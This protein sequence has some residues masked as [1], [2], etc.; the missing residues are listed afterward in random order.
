MNPAKLVTF[1]AKAKDANPARYTTRLMNI[2]AKFNDQHG[3][4]RLLIV[5]YAIDE[6]VLEPPK[7]IIV[8]PAATSFGEVEPVWRAE[9]PLINFTLRKNGEV[10]TVNTHA[11]PNPILSIQRYWRGGSKISF[12]YGSSLTVKENSSLIK[13]ILHNAINSKTI[14]F[15][16]REPK[17]LQP[18]G[19]SINGTDPSNPQIIFTGQ[20]DQDPFPTLVFK[21]H[22]KNILLF[23]QDPPGQ[24][25]LVSY[26][27][28][29]PINLP[30]PSLR[31]PEIILANPDVKSIHQIWT[32][33][34]PTIQLPLSQPKKMIEVNAASRILTR[35]TLGGLR[36]RIFL[37]N[38]NTYVVNQ[39]R[40]QIDKALQQARNHWENTNCL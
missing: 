19:F 17:L 31:A 26:Q 8:T 34:V 3:N 40:S 1:E 28:D 32:S 14:S 10:V 38:G 29:Y 20:L 23:T 7:A 27:Y 16:Q 6:I 13:T 4:A 39:R 24:F 33:V 36:T 22:A 11:V 12:F 18:I 9:Q 15:P 5:P 37:P 30:A 2:Q 35:R 21:F 25:R